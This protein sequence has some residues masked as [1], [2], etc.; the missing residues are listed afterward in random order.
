MRLFISW[1]AGKDCMLAM[2][3]ILQQ[4]QHEVNYLINMCDMDQV[5]S[6]SHGLRKHLI[7]Q[8]AS[9]LGIELIQPIS[10][11][12]TYETQFKAAIKQ[13][14]EKGINAGVFGD[15]Y[16]QPHR[17]WIEKV[18][19]DM[20]IQPL[21]PLWENNTEDLL[22]EFLQA[23][24]KS[25]IVSVNSHFLSKSWLGKEINTVLVNDILNLNN[26]D[27]CAEN[28]EFH[29]FVYDG[30]IFKRPV[31]FKTEKIYFKD[32]HWFLELQ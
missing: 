15:I 9:S 17:Q 14:K 13:V 21:F 25:I 27:P 28:G 24:F 10:D 3:R 30:P 23:G 11:F 12:E 20:D 32:P 19:W 31:T 18:C 1:S 8:Q 6:R 22:K 2:Y 26:I 7:V 5:H 29:S 4:K 16:L